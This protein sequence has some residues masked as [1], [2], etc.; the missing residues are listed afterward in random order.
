MYTKNI[1]AQMFTLGE[2]TVMTD[3]RWEVRFSEQTITLGE[4]EVTLD[5][6]TL[7]LGRREVTLG[8]RT[9]TVGNERSFD[10]KKRTVIL[11]EQK[12]MLVGTEGVM[13]VISEQ[14]V[15]NEQTTK[16]N[17]LHF[18]LKGAGIML[19]EQTVSLDSFPAEDGTTWTVTLGE[20]AATLLGGTQTIKVVD[21]GLV[22]LVGGGDHTVRLDEQYFTLKNRP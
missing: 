15:L 19:G 16:L 3:D 14:E 5:G 22:T 12:V 1:D 13:A 7:T 9:V 8:E 10:L 11:G 21:W 20:R 2:R 18:T 6:Q 4:Q 17:K